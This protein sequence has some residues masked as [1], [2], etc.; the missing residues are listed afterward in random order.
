[1]ELFDSS[2]SVM[3]TQR[4]LSLKICYCGLLISLLDF[5]I[6]IVLSSGLVI[7]TFYDGAG[8]VPMG[9]Y[10]NVLV[11]DDNLVFCFNLYTLYLLYMH[12]PY[13]GLGVLQIQP[14]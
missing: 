10:T 11:Y 12:I 3:F 9:P 4:S 13:I 1:M 2:I 14:L 5:V 7:C 8:F 6:W